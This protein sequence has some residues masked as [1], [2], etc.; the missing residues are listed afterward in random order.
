MNFR[1]QITILVLKL[2]VTWAHD[3]RTLVI[4]QQRF[5]THQKILSDYIIN[6]HQLNTIYCPIHHRST[7]YIVTDHLV[8]VPSNH[9]CIILFF[10][11]NPIRIPWHYHFCWVLGFMKLPGW[12]CNNH[13]KKHMSSSLGRIIIPKILWKII[14]LWNHQTTIWLWLT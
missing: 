2:M 4:N 13:L 14:D 10:P 3:L 11:W 5:W 1:H 6:K 9:H 8:I 7:Q 12:W